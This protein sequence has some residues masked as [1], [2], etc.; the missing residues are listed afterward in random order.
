MVPDNVPFGTM[1]TL[2]GGDFGSDG[3]GAVPDLFVNYQDVP[4]GDIDNQQ[5][6]SGGDIVPAT[7]MIT[8]NM[9]FHYGENIVEI[10]ALVNGQ[11]QSAMTTFTVARPTF[12]I[13]PEKGPRGTK[14]TGTGSGWL[15]GMTDFVTISY[16][17]ADT[18]EMAD[19]AIVSANEA[20]EIWT[21][22]TIPSFAVFNDEVNLLITARDGKGNQSL[23]S[24]YTV[25]VPTIVVEPER[26]APGEDVMVTG[27]GFQPRTQIQEVSIGNSPIVPIYELGLTDATGSFKVEGTVPGVME[28]GHP[29][30]VRVT[31]P[32]GAPITTPFTVIGG[33]AGA[34]TVEE[35]FATVKL[36]KR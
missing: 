7:F 5:L 12:T 8:Q 19:V 29:V 32:I 6:S 31:Q 35:G 18:G 22:F 2:S 14:V 26:A 30:R 28:G 9:G 24:T 13:D 16:R 10:R 1:I 21:Q 4:Q 15:T 17:R 27:K 34:L 33:A 23:S 20:G 36:P 3:A 25:E 11:M